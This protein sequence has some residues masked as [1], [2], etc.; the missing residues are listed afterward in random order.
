MDEKR[1]KVNYGG[2]ALLPLFIFLGL[3]IGCGVVFAVLGT[4]KPFNVFP[5]Y[6]A[7]LIGILV[8]FFCYDRE[9]KV[10]DKA[11]IYYAGAGR[12]GVMT[13]ALIALLAGGFSGACSAIGGKESMVNLG[14][15]L[16]PAPLL[17]PGIFLMCAVISTCIGTSMGTVSVMAPVAVALASGT[18]LNLGAAVAAVL[19]GATFGDNLSMISDTT[20][21]A[22]KGVG[23]EMKDK[24]RM[25]FK[26]VLIPAILAAV[27][28]AVFASNTGA[29]EAEIG[30]YNIPTILPYFAV[31]I[32]A[33]MGLDVII[34][35]A[36]GMGLA[37]VIGLLCGT[38]DFF[39]WAQGV[40]SGM[41]GMFWFV[42]FAMMVSGLVG[43]IRYY[44]GI[45]WLVE[46]ARGIIKGRKSCEF[47]IAL[48]PMVLAAIIANN[49]LGILC[50]AP[51]ANE[52]GKKY[53]IAPMRLAALLD[54]GACIGPMIMP[55]GTLMLMC[56]EYASCDYLNV[57]KFEFYPL[58]LLIG[59]VIVILTGLFRTKE[60][61][62][63]E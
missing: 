21:A 2:K 56:Q 62:A 50:T 5:R 58:L 24:F 34:V 44:G 32:L 49:T 26:I 35:L 27:F 10:A 38:A 46:K 13:L 42:V 3:Y 30:S 51:V 12:S 63:V 28:Y 40:G 37:L 1:S 14:A 48:F 31:L 55:H 17:I 19:T 20:I 45:D 52:L 41:E 16:I 22:T 11:E 23:A 39:A 29:S 53:K 6:V 7:L 4:E 47:I 57:L 54:I 25:N 61:K 60:E 59:V 8:A 18:G 33:V 36:I 9:E 15:T 43:M